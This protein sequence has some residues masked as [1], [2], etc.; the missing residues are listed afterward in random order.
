MLRYQMKGIIMDYDLFTDEKIEMMET[1]SEALEKLRDKALFV[2]DQRLLEK[3][4]KV[5]DFLKDKTY[6][7]IPATEENKTLAGLSV[8]Y[9][10]LFDH[11]ARELVAIGGGIVGDMTGYAAATFKRGIPLTLV[12]TTLLSMCDSS[13]GGKTGVNLRGIKNYVGTFK[14]PERILIAKDFLLTLEDRELRS[15]LGEIIKYGLIADPSI[16]ETLESEDYS[17]RELPY[18]ELIGKCLRIKGNLVRHDFLDKGQRNVLN[19]GHSVGHG[20][21]GYLEG[22][23]THGEAVA[24]GVLTELRI[25]ED[26][27]HLNKEVFR[28]T[29]EIMRKYGMVTKVRLGDTEDILYYIRKDKKNDEYLR[30]TLLKGIGD[31]EIRVAVTEDEIRHALKSIMELLDE[32]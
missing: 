17:L 10:F 22:H 4:V 2:V 16:L 32:T 30:F 6:I 5:R 26:R 18:L 27:L 1:I 29:Q 15:G 20:L 11:D 14:K 8:L 28:L 23:L 25:S 3:E 21:E 12:P 13:V 7:C 19:F 24:L 9:D 31:A